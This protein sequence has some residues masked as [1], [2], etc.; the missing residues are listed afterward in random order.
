M[1]DFPHLPHAPITEA[2]I[3]FRLQL[4]AGRRPEVL[5]Q[6][7][8]Q[9]CAQHVDSLPQR[10]M[11]ARAMCKANVFFEVALSF[12]PDGKPHARHANVVGWPEKKNEQKALAQKVT[13]KMTLE[14]RS[15][16]A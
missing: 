4:D 12:L 13:A 11:K 15:N 3:D 5:N 2:I 1:N 14:L 9:L 7:A 8:K 10:K 16:L 6:V